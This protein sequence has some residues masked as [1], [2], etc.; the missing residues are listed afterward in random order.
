MRPIPQGSL[1]QLRRISRIMTN[2]GRSTHQAETE[3]A[4]ALPEFCEWCGTPVNGYE[5]CFRCK[6]I[7]E[8]T[9]PE[10]LPDNIVLLTYAIHG[11][12]SAA[13]AYGYKDATKSAAANQSLSRLQILTNFFILHHSGCVRRA[14]GSTVDAITHVPSGQGRHPHPLEKEIERLFPEEQ[15]RRVSLNLADSP[16]TAGRQESVNPQ[17][18][19]VADTVEGRHVLVLED[20]W[21]RG[22]SALSAVAS[23]KRA[24]ASAVSLL[25]LTRYL[26]PSFKDTEKWLSERDELTAYDPRF[27]PVTRTFSCPGSQT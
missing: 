11:S 21:V 1:P 26:R 23:L 22:Y 15:L 3:G 9:D 6:E 2:V 25:V 4:F 19:D 20:T 10:L 5:F 13:D 24:G 16:R 27:C 8:S 7:R 12:Q 18:H 14:T 17:R